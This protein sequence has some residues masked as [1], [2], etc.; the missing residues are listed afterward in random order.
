MHSEPKFYI[1][2]TGFITFIRNTSIV[3]NTFMRKTS[4][5]S[6]QNITGSS[7]APYVYVLFDSVNPI[8]LDLSV[9][10]AARQK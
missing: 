5:Y 2:I 7:L 8:D 4:T 9:Y 1:A 6:M 10:C 3:K